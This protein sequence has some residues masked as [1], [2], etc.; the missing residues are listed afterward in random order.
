M[1]AAGS[2]SF[3]TNKPGCFRLETPC[4]VFVCNAGDE[5]WRPILCSCGGFS[6]ARERDRE[7]GECRLFAGARDARKNPSFWDRQKFRLSALFAVWLAGGHRD[8]DQIQVWGASLLPLL[9][10]E[11]GVQ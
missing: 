4:C 2:H 9:F 8:W 11:S 5:A 6:S 7:A 3:H 1:L 10:R